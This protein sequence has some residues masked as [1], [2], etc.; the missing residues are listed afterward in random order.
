METG[1]DSSE[2]T[3][4]LLKNQAASKQLKLRYATVS[5]TSRKLLNILESVKL[6]WLKA[7]ASMVLCEKDFHRIEKETAGELTELRIQN[8]ASKISKMKTFMNETIDHVENLREISI[9]G[10]TISGLFQVRYPHFIAFF[11]QIYV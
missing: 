10:K 6:N 7:S 9:L 4:N 11:L 3:R 2:F 1:T 8:V 5:S